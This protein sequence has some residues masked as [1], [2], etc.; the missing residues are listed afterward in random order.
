MSSGM[1]FQSLPSPVRG[2]QG[3]FRD[4]SA[5]VRGTDPGAASEYSTTERAQAALE[6]EKNGHPGLAQGNGGGGALTVLQTVDG[7]CYRGTPNATAGGSACPEIEDCEFRRQ[8]EAPGASAR[9]AREV[10]E[11]FRRDLDRSVL[12]SL[13]KSRAPLYDP[14]DCQRM[15]F[16]GPDA[17]AFVNGRRYMGETY[18]E[19]VARLS[20]Q[21]RAER[22]AYAKNADGPC[23]PS[24]PPAQAAT[25]ELRLDV[26]SVVDGI[27]KALDAKE[28][29]EPC[30][31]AL[32]AALDRAEAPPTGREAA[33][34]GLSRA[35]RFSL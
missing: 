26:K 14:A 2:R 7:M 31:A 24:V 30:R 18:D 25:Y 8:S 3:F 6:R 13:A 11:A 17:E 29:P 20:V 22:D 23:A 4:S 16:P 15:P 1:S 32:R 12:E 33:D 34:K 35:I 27:V 10:A 21:W 9:S 19:C 28:V 5:E